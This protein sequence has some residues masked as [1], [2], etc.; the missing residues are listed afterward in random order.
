MDLKYVL[1]RWVAYWLS[2]NGSIYS[3]RNVRLNGLI[4][5]S[6]SPCRRFWNLCADQCSF[7][8]GPGICMYSGNSITVA[9]WSTI[10]QVNYFFC[11]L[12]SPLFWFHLPDTRWALRCWMIEFALEPYFALVLSS[13]YYK[14]S[15]AISIGWIPS[16]P[17][18][19]LSPFPFAP[20]STCETPLAAIGRR[21]YGKLIHFPAG[22]RAFLSV[23][24]R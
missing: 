3:T 2:T 7:D 6:L 19:L 24:V 21:D 23:W 22:F 17:P 5:F 14:Q 10:L 15:L 4:F 9:N 16:P 8:C 13:L 18:F 20:N 11:F 12:A 1:S